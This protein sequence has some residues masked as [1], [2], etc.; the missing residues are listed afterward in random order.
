MANI[1]I[2]ISSDASGSGVTQNQEKTHGGVKPASGQPNEANKSSQTDNIVNALVLQQGKKVLSTAINTY[3]NLSGDTAMA[4]RMN[5][6]TTMAG[7]L[8]TI[9]VAGWLGAVAVA[10]DIGTQAFTSVVE[11][12][13]ANAQV[14]LLRERIGN[15]TINGSRGTYD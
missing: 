8:G 5:M 11:T 12:R 1:V 9:A 7:W 10:V 4:N 13:K 15:S 14:E 6:M 3:V 2:K